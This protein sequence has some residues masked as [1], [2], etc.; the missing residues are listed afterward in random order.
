MA[1]AVAQGVRTQ[2]NILVDRITAIHNA[3]S[4]KHETAIAEFNKN[5]CGTLDKLFSHVLSNGA[6]VQQQ[7]QQ[8]A[9]PVVQQQQQQAAAVVQQQQQHAAAVDPS[10]SVYFPQ[11]SDAAPGGGATNEQ[12]IAAF[13]RQSVLFSKLVDVLMAGM[14]E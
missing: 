2:V 9:A 8:Q 6:V 3:A 11:G 4:L 10:A 14:S 12:V 1:I 5:V 7:Q 13:E